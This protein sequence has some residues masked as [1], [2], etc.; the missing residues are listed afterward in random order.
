[1]WAAPH[2]TVTTCVFLCVCPAVTP[3]TPGDEFRCCV[4]EKVACVLFIYLFVFKFNGPV[5]KILLDL[6]FYF[7]NIFKLVKAEFTVHKYIHKS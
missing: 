6:G 2:H 5:C 4:P 3:V 1:M 7:I